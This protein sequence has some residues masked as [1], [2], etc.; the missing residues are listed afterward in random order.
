MDKMLALN[1]PAPDELSLETRD[2]P[3]PPEGWAL[4]KVEAV[5]VCG[6]DIHAFSGHQPFFTYPRVLGHEICATIAAVNGKSEFKIGERVVAVPY[7]P[8]GKCGACKNGKPN[9]CV[10]M[11]TI[12]AHID[13]AMA[14]YTLCPLFAL[15]SVDHLKLPAEQLAMIEPM[16]IGAHTARRAAA[17]SGDHALV[18]GAGP[19][20][21]ASAE[22]LKTYGVKVMFA[23]VSPR[24]TAVL[25][26]KFGY[27]VLDP[28]KEGFSEKLA[29]WAGG[30]LPDVVVD[31]TGAK[32]S[33]DNSYK[34]VRPGGRV[35]FVGLF[36]GSFVI[37]DSHFHLRELELMV[38]RTATRED[39]AYVIAHIN[40]LNLKDYVS[41]TCAL[42]ESDKIVPQ[43]LKLG[44]EV[45]K[46]CIIC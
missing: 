11:T 9:A 25:K 29:E 43:W 28:T 20:G 31:A 35:I 41:H 24:R 10:H 22:L 42:A 37:D 32:A 44:P 33:M 21:V 3:T 46:G 17:R 15:I 4:L 5:G 36:P 39:F 12:G 40:E 2:I 18:C 19:I 34:Y 23:E 8:C 30:E 7:L 1:V 13:G 26:E 16:A 45:F 27:D 6:S 38:S 14:S